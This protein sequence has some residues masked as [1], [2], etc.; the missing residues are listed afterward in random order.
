MDIVNDMVIPCL[1]SFVACCAFG[2]QFNIRPGHLI[3]ASVGS[4]VSQLIFSLTEMWGY[5]NIKCCFIAAAAVAVYSEAM[6]RFCKAPV[7]MYLIVGMIP[8]VPG[9]LIY[10]TMIALMT[11]DNETFLDRAVDAFSAA[12]AIAMGIFAVSS[13]VR[14]GA[15]LIKQSGKKY[16]QSIKNL[17]SKNGDVKKF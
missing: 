14:I 5:S 13:A 8:L 17:S 9:G 6:A 3:A 12:G 4:L 15:D 11:G 1:C 10:Y 16:R 7:N 2:V